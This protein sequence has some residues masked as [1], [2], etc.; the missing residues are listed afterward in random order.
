MTR[1]AA[2]SPVA[3]G[4]DMISFTVGMNLPVRHPRIDA[5][6][7]EACYERNSTAQDYASESLSIEAR[8]RRRLAEANAYDQQRQ[9]FQQRI[10]PKARQA[11]EVSM[12]E[13]TVG[14]TTLIQVLENYSEILMFQ[15]QLAR[16]EASRAAA[17]AQLE[18]AIGCGSPTNAAPMDGE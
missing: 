10:I 3:D 18:R 2:L 12:A 7:R 5:G 17:L 11:L 14:K 9:L 13:Y 16:V 6:I 1:D 15:M 4:L 8:L